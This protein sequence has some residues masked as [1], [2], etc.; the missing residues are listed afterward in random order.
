MTDWETRYQ[1]GDTPWEKGTPAPPLL[2]WLG[3][4]EIHGRVLVPGCGSGHDV[5]ALARA[6]AAP[7][8][9]DIAP[10]AIQRADAHTRA[11]TER[12]EVADLFALPGHLIGAFDWIFEHTCFC[13]IDPARRADY[14]AGVVS[15][16]KPHGRLLAIFYLDPDHD[17]D[18][19]PH[20]VAHEEIERLFGGHFETITAY[21]P[22]LAYPGREGRE[23]VC[24]LRR[25]N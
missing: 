23:L 3:R 20:R 18:G 19:P 17:E 1:T 16:L 9:I 13:A 22:E 12:Y 2:E 7:V 4:H 15:A 14:V 24:M 25:R 8:G 11:G 21:V 10:S 6:G 5:R